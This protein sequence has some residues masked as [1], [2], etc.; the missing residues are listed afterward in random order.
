MVFAVVIGLV[1]VF[2]L[3]RGVR[4]WLHLRRLRTE[5]RAAAG[6]VTGHETRAGGSRAVIVA[7][8]DE[9]G[10]PRQLT[11]NLSSAVPTM[12]IGSPVTV[13]YLAG[14]PAS[15]FLDE[16]RENVRSV[17]FYVILGLG[18]TAAGLSLA[19]RD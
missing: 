1:G 8:T 10:T 12:P 3:Y 4:E 7:Y 17:L 5:G 14:D 18:F 11:S 2:V 13:R 15:A 6:T 9:L 19:L 16:R